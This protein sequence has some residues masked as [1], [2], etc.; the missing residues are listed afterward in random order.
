MRKILLTTFF[1]VSSIVVTAQTKDVSCGTT[2]ETS[3]ETDSLLN[4]MRQSPGL[5]RA[6][7]NANMNICRLAVEIDSDTYAEFAGDTAAIRRDVLKMVSWCSKIYEAE[8]NTRLV[9]S[10]IRIWKPDEPDPFRGINDSGVW[11]T[12][13]NQMPLA[14]G[15]DKH[16]YLYTKPNNGFGGIAY[17]S[18]VESVSPLYSPQVL[19]HELGH[20]FSSP[21]THSCNWPGGPIDYCSA[22]E[23]GCYD[24][25]LEML[26]VSSIMSYCNSRENTFHPLSREIMMLHAAGHFTSIGSAPEQVSLQPAYNAGQQDFFT[27]DPILSATSYQLSISQNPDFSGE[28]ITELPFNGFETSQLVAGTGYYFR[29][30]AVNALGASDWSATSIL[31]ITPKNIGT[32]V[33][34]APL[35]SD[36]RTE[37]GSSVQLIFNA[38]AGASGYEIQ[39]SHALDLGFNNAIVNQTIPT[40]DFSFT[41]PYRMPMRW[42]VRAVNGSEKGSWSDHSFILPNVSPYNGFILPAGWNGQQT[43]TSFPYFYSMLDPISHVRVTI[44]DNSDFSSPISVKEQEPTGF[45]KDLPANQTLY[46]KVEEWNDNRIMYP[47]IPLTS[48]VMTLTTGSTKLPD[49]ITFLTA[50]DAKLFG[51]LSQNMAVSNKYVW[52]EIPGTGYIRMHPINL[53]YQ[54]FNRNTTDGLIGSGMLPRS[55]HSD[56]NQ[57]VQFMSRGTYNAVR[58]S[59]PVNE[60]LTGEST[61]VQFYENV[62]DFDPDGKVAWSS[63]QIFWE[64]NGYVM[65]HRYFAPNEYIIQVKV[66]G[67]KVWTLISDLNDGSN[68]IVVTDLENPSYYETISH[69]TQPGIQNFIYQLELATNGTIWLRQLDSNTGISSVASYNGSSWTVYDRNNSPINSPYTLALAPNGIPYVLETGSQSSIY[70]FKDGAWENMEVEMPY[71][72]LSGA[73]YVDKYE[74]CW[75]TSIFGVVRI[76]TSGLLPVTLVSFEADKEE[77]AVKLKWQVEDEVDMLEYVVEHSTDGKKFEPA[78]RMEAAKKPY[79]ELRHLYPAAGKNYY[80]LKSVETDQDFALSKIVT[81][82]F[83]DAADPYLYPNPTQNTVHITL[84]PEQTGTPGRIS[85]ITMEGKKL[86]DKEVQLLKTSETVDLSSLPGGRYFIRIDN[87]KETI[88]RPVELRR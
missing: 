88:S 43:L 37:T 20:N 39:I 47:E 2:E 36:M 80:R 87:G 27:F 4:L 54:I 59:R 15:F 13:I 29:I 83:P 50:T 56:K 84:L 12:R 30:K 24:K 71:E 42:R 74:S 45:F 41:I 69:N 67:T 85:V 65:Q 52:F 44:D 55:V 10:V 62:Q 31:S 60:D 33:I 48:Y 1:L 58:W 11:L 46:L 57:M 70:R 76:A 5:M 34:T 21:H 49:K 40:T 25:S 28:T 77:H 72:N 9:V 6:R 14:V 63:Q 16:I 53:D 61:V 3:R 75:L 78:G 8:I 7:A 82:T 23:Y 79:Y 68:R 86:V 81:V 64:K 18:G 17:L 66:S 38:A 22:P 51:A 32:P 73:M 35:G 19:A 26:Q